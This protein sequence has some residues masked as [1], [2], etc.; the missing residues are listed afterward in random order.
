[1]P[2]LSGEECLSQIRLLKGYEDVPVIIIST[3][4]YSVDIED[5]QR[6]GATHFF[7]KVHTIKT[8]TDTITKL[9]SEKDL[10]Y[11]LNSTT[12]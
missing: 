5:C 7:T 12:L 6:L 3:S 9:V 8:L 4:S 10:P 1:M 11:V 2:L